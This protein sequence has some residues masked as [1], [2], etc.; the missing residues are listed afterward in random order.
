MENLYRIGDF[1]EK[2]GVTPDWLKY[3]EKLGI[4]HPFTQKNGY[5][6]Y[7][8]E[9]ASYVY[10]CMQLKNM[11]FGTEEI[12][13]FI[14]GGTFEELIDA[15][16]D[17]RPEVC[18]QIAFEE[19][20][21]MQYDFWQEIKELFAMPG[22]W[23]IRVMPGFYFLPFSNRNTFIEDEETAQRNREW[24]RWMPVV[25]QTQ[26]IFIPDKYDEVVPQG[27][28]KC[29]WGLSVRKDFA[30]GIGLNVDEPAIYVPPHRCMEFYC[31]SD[32]DKDGPQEE[33]VFWPGKTSN[34]SLPDVLPILK[35]H[36][37]R[38]A[39]DCY[40]HRI[41]KMKEKGHRIVYNILYVP[42]N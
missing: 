37:F 10:C 29:Q 32:M 1:S 14:N 39:G 31:R 9:Q 5:R 12:L 24:N 22:N 20:L 40:T 3:Y 19:A 4:L 11:G 33:A 42:I 18:R 13:Y 30:R 25:T 23:N 35:Q 16:E 21:L 34:N 15:L 26:R 8:F 36:N 41:I 6:Y 7:G 27:P 2:L 17:K 38:I 28:A